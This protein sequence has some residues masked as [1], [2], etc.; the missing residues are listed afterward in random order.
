MKLFDRL[1]FYLQKSVTF[2]SPI[3]LFV[4]RIFVKTRNKVLNHFFRIISILGDWWC[5]TVFSLIILFFNTRLG[6]LIIV[7]QTFQVAL[8]R[9]VKLT[10]LR[11]RPY[12]KHRLTISR[13][14]VPPDK[15]S[16]PS[17]H[18]AGA[19][20][21]FFCINS[22]LPS[23]SWIFLI[24]AILVGISRIYLGVHYFT[25][26]LFGILLGFIAFEIGKIVVDYI[27]NFLKI[28]YFSTILDLKLP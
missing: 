26:V 11:K 18:T 7:S 27:L 20:V 9:L 6:I 4:S 24:L 5:W 21:I 1:K 15:F 2:V 3:D 13:L 12:I 28:N 10:F 14:I 8:Q 22:Y 23:I 17:G 16:F 25:D 19:F